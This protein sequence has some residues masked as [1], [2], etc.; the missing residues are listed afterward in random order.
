VH[1]GHAALFIFTR[2]VR[3]DGVQRGLSRQSQNNQIL[4]QAIESH[5]EYRID[6]CRYSI[7]DVID[8]KLV[9]QLF[10]VCACG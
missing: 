7:H 8:I 5:A 1:Q 2:F 3:A 6:S 9:H 10:I 4:Q